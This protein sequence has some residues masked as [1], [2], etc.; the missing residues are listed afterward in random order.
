[1]HARLSAA[2]IAAVWVVGSGAHA[3]CLQSRTSNCVNLDLVPQISHEIAAEEPVSPARKPSPLADAE[4][5]YTGPTVGFARN[6]G[7]PT[8]GYK[9]ALH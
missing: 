3:A 6:F 7:A 2:T 5:P 9:W 1:M 8:F 4:T